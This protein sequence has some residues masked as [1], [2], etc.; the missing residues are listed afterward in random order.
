MS[1]AKELGHDGHIGWFDWPWLYDEWVERAPKNATLVELG[2]AFGKSISYLAKRAIAKGRDDLRIVGVDNWV[3][4]D[5]IRRDF[6]EELDMAGGY[7]GACVNQIHMYTG[8][9]VRDRV[10]LVRSD[11]VQASAIFGFESVWGVYVDAGHEE[12][13]VF[14]DL[15]AWYP[16]IA[17]GGE[18]A[19]HD[20]GVFPGVDAALRR[21]NFKPDF[22]IQGSTWRHRKT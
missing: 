4:A 7:F 14:A 17:T 16:R 13:E 22:E 19:G 9:Q 5:W 21:F 1:R 12:A 20:L 10:M 6:G 8:R 2:V 11:T 18:I 3:G 15:C